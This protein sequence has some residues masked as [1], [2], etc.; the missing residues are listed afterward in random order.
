MPSEPLRFLFRT[1][2]SRL[3]LWNTAVVL[4]L[5]LVNY[6]AIGQGL[7]QTL[8]QMLDE[9]VK[10]ELF[11]AERDYNRLKAE[12]ARMHER[13]NREV[14]GHPRRRLFIQLIDESGRLDWSSEQSPDADV[15]PSSE[16]AFERPQTVRDYRIICRVVSG[17]AGPRLILRVGCSLGRSQ[18]EMS[19]FNNT[20]LGV[21]I[22]LLVAVPLGGYVLAGRAAR[23]LEQI[24]QTTARLN[25]AKLDERLPI[26]G[27]HDLLDEL[28]RTINQFLDRIADYLRQSRDFTANAAHELRSPLTALQSSLE[29]ALNTDR[30]V[31][32]YKDV[33]TVLLDE[34]SQLRVLV[35]QLLLLAEGDA[36]RLDLDFEPVRLD[37][38]VTSS[39]EMLTVV[40]ETRE[41]SLS[42][43]CLDPVVIQ[44]DGKRL[45]QI[46]NNLIDN[47]LK[48]TPPGGRV[49]V[50]LTLE[51]KQ[52]RCVLEVTDSGCG[53]A[54][55][56]LPHI[57]ER[58]YQS[59]KARERDT[60]SRGLGLGL[61]I[62]QTVVAA[63]G[64]SIHVA[65]TIGKGATF[66]VLL[67][68]RDPPRDRKGMAGR[69]PLL[70]LS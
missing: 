7:Q 45:W 62:C 59:D 20:L 35:N 70:K 69:G 61:S 21:G 28:S 38:I 65:S 41:I 67:P 3:T 27:S 36:G 15:L 22:A 46:V 8:T 6:L 34:C 33:L 11:A 13:F 44:G 56:D 12:P 40:A 32:E 64:G 53:I 48:F 37:Q 63:H 19:R 26:R 29:I 42:I 39:L 66:T 50:A 9:F 25:P 49:R 43:D 10:E 58:F 30:S 68:V 31:E 17:D 47:A 55:Q 14:T 5:L 60:P 18:H 1:F 57:F 16:L 54:P 23:P 4:V 2:R 24:I 51:A 52:H